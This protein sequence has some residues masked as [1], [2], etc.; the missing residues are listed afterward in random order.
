MRIGEIKKGNE[1]GRDGVYKYVW[2]ACEGCGLERWVAVLHGKPRIILCRSCSQRRRTRP[3]GPDNHNWKGGRTT[4]PKGYIQIRLEP[5]DFFLPMSAGDTGYVSEHR[6]V[7][8]KHLGR[9]LNS[10]EIV[11]H[12]G[13][14]YPKGSI[15]NRQDNRIENLQLAS[16]LGHNQLTALEKKIDSLVEGQREL[17]QE[18]RLLRLENKVLKDNQV[19][20]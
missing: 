5:G 18:I 10:W 8:A 2:A 17:K 9:C 12:K 15:E 16:D 4:N 1:I 20:R 3:W 11:H 7:M 6:L 19:R 13:T 14:K